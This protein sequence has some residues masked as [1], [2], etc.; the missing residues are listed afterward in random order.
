MKSEH[1]HFEEDPLDVKFTVLAPWLSIALQHLSSNFLCIEYMHNL[2]IFHSEGVRLT[3]VYS[4]RHQTI[5]LIFLINP[6]CKI[7]II[8]VST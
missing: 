7:L 3:T 8:N 5:Q 2:Y 6:L 4:Y 1:R